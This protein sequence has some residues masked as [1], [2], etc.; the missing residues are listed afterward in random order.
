MKFQCLK[1]FLPKLLKKINKILKTSKKDLQE[2]TPIFYSEKKYS[3]EI[4]NNEIFQSEI[5]KNPARENKKSLISIQRI[6]EVYIYLIFL[7]LY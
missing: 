4:G 5:K 2:F 6:N 7:Y 3:S 1:E